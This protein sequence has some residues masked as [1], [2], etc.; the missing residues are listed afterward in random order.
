VT[1]SLDLPGTHPIQANFG[2]GSQDA[3][4][5]ELNAS[6]SDLVYSTYLG[7]SGN[8][9]G[10]GIALDTSGSAYVTGSTDSSELSS[11]GSTDAF[12]T[13]L[14]PL[15]TSREYFASWAVA[16]MI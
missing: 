6:G 2:G 1:D 3:F 7:G 5:L 13:K 4:V 9:R 11:L 10:F 12:V 14:S 15:G 8:D 16:E